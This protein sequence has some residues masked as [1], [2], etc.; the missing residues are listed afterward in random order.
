MIIII[1]GYNLLKHI[2]PHIKGSLKKE[3]DQLIRQLGFYKKKKSGTIKEIVLVFDGG[4]TGRA[5]REIRSGITVVFSGQ[6]ESA[7]E[8]IVDYVSRNKEKELALV[9]RDRKLISSCQKENVD[10]INL[11]DFYDIVQNTILEDAISEIDTEK[12]D[13]HVKK[14]PPRSTHQDAQAGRADMEIDSE[15]LDI[16]MESASTDDYKKVDL[17]EDAN[18]R[19]GASRKPSKKEKKILSKV[20]KL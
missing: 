3:R 12:Q 13:S 17:V 16:L 1:D 15:A 2:F 20:K 8:W 19:K 9:T 5:T 10:A 18:K 14:Y 6:K 4:F 7:D 11:V